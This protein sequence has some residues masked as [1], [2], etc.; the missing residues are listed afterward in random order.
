MGGVVAASVCALFLLSLTL[1]STSPDTAGVAGSALPA[2]PDRESVAQDSPARPDTL[3]ADLPALRE[4]D[5]L[6]ILYLESRIKAEEKRLLAQFCRS[7]GLVPEWIPAENPWQLLTALRNG[8]GDIIASLDR[9]VHAGPDMPVESTLSWGVT[10]PQVVGRDSGGIIDEVQDLSVRQIAVRGQSPGRSVIASLQENA[11]AMDVIDIPADVT[12]REVLRRVSSGRYDLAVMNSRSLQSLLADFPDLKMQLPLGEAEHRHWLVHRDATR[13]RG[14]LNRFINRKHLEMDL[15][16]VYREDLAALKKRKLLRL[17]T[18][19]S[20]VN[21]FFENGRL[22]GF[23][24]ELIRRFAEEHGMRVDVVIARDQAEMQSLLEQGRGDVIA[25]SL[26]RES[27]PGNADVRLSRAYNY[28]A[29]VL[30]G[31]SHDSIVQEPRD[32]DGRR[33][34][35]PKE[36]PWRDY[37]ESLRTEYGIDMELPAAEEGI[38]TETVLFRVARGMYD[39][40]VIGSHEQEAEFSRQLNLKAHLRLAEPRPQA[41]AVRASDTQL[42]AALNEF[43][44]REYRRGFYN[45]VYSRYIERPST[46]KASLNQLAEMEQISP[47]DRIVHEYAEDFG[48]DWRLIVAQMYQESRFNP[49]AVSYAGAEGLMQLLP[50][51]A[52]EMGVEE[53]D[54]PAHNIRGGVRY[55]DYLRGRFEDIPQ[56]QDRIWFSLAAYNA[57]YKRISQARR[58]AEEMGLNPNRWF[59]NVETAMLA[60]ARPYR[61][62]GE[63]TRRCRCGQTVVYVREIRTLYN[64]YVRITESVRSAQRRDS[65]RPAVFN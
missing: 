22:R 23:E 26:P 37:L 48:F 30:V 44:G 11:P 45:V 42:L 28:T 16:R 36:S 8:H 41:W 18:Y 6:R 57:G 7:R 2:S 39:L 5:R 32:L 47:F 65:G 17:I 19:R 46:R 35:L 60:L 62:D 58:L 53:R 64:N 38:D 61:L 12:D 13:L 50:G 55:L 63:W 27:V 40:T 15:A 43:I 14:S 4:Q 1:S 34:Y 49:A 59:D 33:I 20:P 9:S 25:A 29:P 21:V 52:E 54:D 10:Q 56:L 24:Y 3:P 51:T 31:R